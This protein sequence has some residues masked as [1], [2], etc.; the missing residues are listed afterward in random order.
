MASPAPSYLER[1]WWHGRTAARSRTGRAT[2]PPA[3]RRGSPFG[4]TGGERRR[5]RG[6]RPRPLPDERARRG[7]AHAHPPR[8][9]LRRG[10][11]GHG[12]PPRTATASS[13]AATRARPPS[14]TTIDHPRPRRKDEAERRKRKLEQLHEADGRRRGDPGRRPSPRREHGL[15][16]DDAHPLPL[17]VD[18]RRRAR[19][20]VGHAGDAAR[21]PRHQHQHAQRHAR[22]GRSRPPSS[23]KRG[24]GSS[25]TP[26][27]TSSS[28]S[29]SS[30]SSAG[31]PGTEVA[32]L[33]RVLLDRLGLTAP[34]H[35]HK[36]RILA[37]SASLPVEGTERDRSLQVPLRCLRPVR[38][39]AHEADPPPPAAPRPGP[40]PSCRA[41]RVRPTPAQ[42]GRHAGRAV[43][44]CS[45]GVRGD[46]ARRRSTTPDQ[47]EAA[48]RA[49]ADALGSTPT[50]PLRAGRRGVRA[51]A[52]ARVATQPVARPPERRGRATTVSR[53]WPSS[54]F[55]SRGGDARR[56]V[57]GLLVVRGAGDALRDVVARRPGPLST[58]RGRVPVVPRSTPSSGPSRG[59]SPPP[60]RPTPSTRRSGPPGARSA[61]SRSSAATRFSK[62]D[63]DSRGNRMLEILYCECCGELFYGGRRSGTR[64]RVEL[65]PHE[66]DVAGLPDAAQTLLF[67][68][69]SYD[70]YAVFWPSNRDAR[71]EARGGARVAG[72]WVT[73]TLDPA[74]GVVRPRPPADSGGRRR[75]HLRPPEGVR[76]QPA[77][78][79][80]RCAR[81]G[82]PVRVPLL[83]DELRAQ[84][85]VHAALAPPELPGRLRQDDPAPRHRALRRP[86]PR[87]R[88]RQA[89]LVLGQP[90]GGRPRCP[91]RGGR[92]P[93]RPPPRPPRHGAPRR[94]RPSA[95]ETGPARPRAR[96][97]RRRLRRTTSS[98]ADQLRTQIEA[99]ADGPGDAPSPSGASSRATTTSDFTDDGRGA[100]GPAPAVHRR[101]RPISACTPRTRPGVTPVEYRTATKRR[102]I[103]R[104]SSRSSGAPPTGARTPTDARA[105][106]GAPPDR[107]V[108]AYQMHSPTPSSAATTS[109]SRRRGSGTPASSGS[110]PPS[111]TRPT[112][113]SACFTDAYRLRDNP[114]AKDGDEPPK[115]WARRCRRHQA[116]PRLRVREGRG[117]RRTSRPPRRGS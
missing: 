36:L 33:L 35:R 6:P 78:P 85:G 116:E 106:P 107:C 62:R 117:R 40:T 68:D 109:R 71:R 83:R 64:R 41:L 73:A 56:A 89:H 114:W 72:R 53:T 115:P 67:E 21:P 4:L 48:W 97:W 63:D 52:G 25:R 58:P 14:P 37:S 15:E 26:T 31:P 3:R 94:G 10:P 42:R 11:G 47:H 16:G 74:T 32:Y 7:P 61:R 1:R 43:R 88:G 100:T 23:T 79:Q 82:R 92:P 22:C 95:R 59:S 30:T 90:P 5:P 98:L 99:S 76:G 69:L 55:G 50:A 96:R 84:E 20:P 17:P 66:P 80:E 102:S 12:R 105:R 75:P 57:R 65:L 111:G 34:E 112:P 28:S 101:L 103:G 86:P 87:T 91:R 49:V 60:R 93:R 54:L 70:D 27:P 2:G 8:P 19:L 81:D 13:S 113:S 104:S 77:P 39:V 24:R 44:G 51:E 108:T 29:T 46:R 110:T 38:H 9:R 45:T 18:R